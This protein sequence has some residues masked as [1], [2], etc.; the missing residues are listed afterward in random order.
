MSGIT[1]E[2]DW[3]TSKP[4][5]VRIFRGHYALDHRLSIGEVVF[6][7]KSGLQQE[8][9]I[10]SPEQRLR[11][12]MMRVSQLIYPRVAVVAF[13]RA[14]VGYRGGRDSRIGETMLTGGAVFLSARNA[15]N[16]AVC[17]PVGFAAPLLPAL[18]AFHR[19]SGQIFSGMYA[20]GERF[21][22]MPVPCGCQQDQ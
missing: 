6:G 3:R 19:P 9:S 18:P 22:N 8:M 15:C 12:P 21:A 10:P 20:G 2:H 4:A 7:P 16:R 17:E 13:G 11:L 5:M 1:L 14:A